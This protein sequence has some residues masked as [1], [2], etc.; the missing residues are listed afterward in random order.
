MDSVHWQRV[1]ELFEL[2]N[3]QP[4]E[5][6][7]QFLA[8]SC[9]QDRR[10][11]DE[12]EAMLAAGGDDRALAVERFIVDRQADAAGA[13]P[14]LGNSLGPWRLVSALGHG[15]MGTVYRAER[16]DG[17][18]RQEV[19]V[20][21][22]RSGP[23][24]PYA[25]ERFRTERQVLARLIHPNIAGLVDGGF[26]SDG[27]PYLVMELVDGIP[28]TEWCV[29]ER[30][31]LEGR[32]R[33]F[34]V[35]CEA[36]QHAHR[37]LVVHR[38]LRPSNIFVA[39]SGNVKLLDFGIAKLLDPVAWDVEST[40]T[41]AEM[42][43]IT[44]EYGAPEQRQ[45]GPTTT[46]TD[47]YALGVVLYE[48]LT[49]ARPAAFSRNGVAPLNDGTSAPIMPPSEA[50][51]RLACL[52]PE[53]EQA[54][55]PGTG[56]EASPVTDRRKLAR[57][58][59]GDLDRIVMTALRDE[60]D[61]RYASAGQL[62]EEIERFLDGRAVLAQPDTL[63]YRARKFVG[64][65]RLAVTAAA[66]LASCITAFGIVAA[67]Q[68]R[69]LAEQGRVARM[70]QA[71]AEQVVQVLVDLFETTNPAIRPDGD[72]MPIRE[73]LAGAESR[74]LTQLSSTP[75]VK[76]KLQQV[77][78]LIHSQRGQ[79]T[80]ARET[81]EAALAEQRRLLGPDHPDTLGSL[82][83]LGRVLYGSGDGERARTLLQESLDRHRRVYGDE[84]EK[85][86]RALHALAP[87]APNLDA[88]G[89]LFSQALEVRQRVLPPNHPDLAMSLGALAQYH[90][91]K[92]DRERSRALYQ[93][94]LAV[95]EGPGARHP[96]AVGLM[97]DYASLLG[98][99][100]L[101]A[102]AEAMQRQAITVGQQVL[103]SGTLIVANLTN[104]LGTT[105]TSL[106]RLAEAEHAFREAHAQ[107]LALL[108]ENHWRTRNLARNVG[109]IL[110]LQQ[111]YA[112]ALPWMDRAIA[113][114]A[115]DDDAGREGIRAQRA[116]MLFRMGRRAEALEQATAA[117]SALERMTKRDGSVLAISRPLLARMLNEIGRPQD[118][119]PLAHAAVEWLE[120]WGPSD[121]RHAEA[122]CEMGRAQLLQ[123]MTAEG[124]ATLERCLP[125]YRAWGQADREVVETLERLL[126]DSAHRSP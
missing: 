39:R 1:E 121:P 49:G 24:D 77:F 51:R 78:G 58:I 19:A 101:H 89:A 74:A 123:G 28:I 32:L 116:W 119:E 99:L 93:R 47:V 64:R 25:I 43:L 55:K 57:R 71:K 82:H 59:R 11:R 86:A 126:A 72:Q 14:L 30:L 17:Q 122:A 106:G 41:R 9:G 22:V 70:E 83:A 33:L 2:A 35:V 46:A 26:A 107:H 10:L 38:D 66:V 80:P 16:A 84:H 110:A 73:F 81:L 23:R 69:A 91:L 62:A 36:V 61:R 90:N 76:A 42:R 54:Q 60:P 111:Q 63:H 21:L 85:T 115:S 92:A 56:A 8:E 108:G 112:E 102:E 114:R 50:V 125:V 18:Y 68:A 98:G 29:S 120:R 104:N 52:R 88:A 95:F 97:N 48:L 5:A 37:A 117:V 87:L 20:K 53:S 40:A 96:K 94:A 100:N 6:R 65:N 124:R 27:T 4:V 105:L 109:R 31:P 7:R 103:G 34:R 67:L 79:Y 44:P 3:A 118:A 12:L 113:V 45:G 75:V 13:D 15:G